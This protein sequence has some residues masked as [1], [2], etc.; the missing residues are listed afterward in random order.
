M[1][2]KLYN[3]NKS[4]DVSI[5]LSII[6][7]KS[8]DVSIFD[9]SIKEDTIKKINDIVVSNFYGKQKTK[10]IFSK[11]SVLGLIPHIDSV[12]VDIK[13]DLLTEFGFHEYKKF[14]IYT[15]DNHILVIKYIE[16]DV[17]KTNTI[18]M[19]F[20]INNLDTGD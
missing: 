14:N 19:T 10:Y 17:L 16:K 13:R 6:P 15:E 12:T 3:K 1:D 18:T 2:Y 8:R 4:D 5:E 9:D 11:S 20:D 7:D